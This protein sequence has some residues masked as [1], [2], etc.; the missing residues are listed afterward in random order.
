MKS[1]KGTKTLENLLKAWAG[2]SQAVVQYGMFA[3]KAKKEG[4][5]QVS[6]IFQE[7][8]D[9]EREHGK[10]FYRLIL[11]GFE[12]AIPAEVGTTISAGF[13]ESAQTLDNLLFSINGETDEAVTVYPEYA[14]V[15]AEEGFSEAAAAFKAIGSVEKH[16]A[17]RFQMLADNIENGSVFNKKET[18]IWKCNNCGYIAEDTAAP[19][20][21]PACLHPRSY[22]QVEVD[23]Y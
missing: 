21:C 4:Y 3:A 5:V 1:L 23:V 6:N 7:T 8:A 14:R 11:K 18:V 19:E 15:A 16:H 12:G 22:F 17:E 2:E 10:R 20:L 9:N 13:I